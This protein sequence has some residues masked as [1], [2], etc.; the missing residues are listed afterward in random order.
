MNPF[1]AQIEEDAGAII[2]DD[3]GV[4]LILVGPDGSEYATSALD[5]EVPLKCAVF[6]ESRELDVQTGFEHIVDR[7]VAVVRLASLARVPVAGEK[8]FVRVPKSPLDDELR[9]YTLSGPPKPAKTIG[10]INLRLQ[11]V[12]QS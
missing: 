2:E 8:W 4:E 1:L 12:V 6:Q 7:P 11:R 9:T 5:S 10:F 3:L